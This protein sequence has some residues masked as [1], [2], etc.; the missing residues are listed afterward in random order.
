V[1]VATESSRTTA[2]CFYVPKHVPEHTWAKIS[3]TVRAAVS[4]TTTSASCDARYASHLA[5]YTQWADRQGVPLGLD[6]LLDLDLIERYIAVGMPDA[7]DSSRA[8]RRAILRRIAR[9]ASPALNELPP[10]EPFSYR[11]VRAPYTAAEVVAFLR[12]ARTQPTE[13]RRLALTAVLAL[14]LACGLD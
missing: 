1:S 8:A 10:P 14:G 6:S 3:S 2:L 7:A 13:G 11:R 5:A 9:K 12:L 4:L